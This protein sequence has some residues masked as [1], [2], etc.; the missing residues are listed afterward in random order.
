[1][2]VTGKGG[3]RWR[4]TPGKISYMARRDGRG[5][6]FPDAMFC[7]VIGPAPAGAPA[8]PG[9]QSK[10]DKVGENFILLAWR[11]GSTLFDCSEKVIEGS[12]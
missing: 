10:W 5:A 3:C 6:L 8:P 2:E 4:V 7:L 12:Y 9:L 11:K 1:M